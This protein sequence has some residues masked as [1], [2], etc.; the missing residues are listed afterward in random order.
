M[1][2]KINKSLILEGVASV[3]NDIIVN[4]TIMSA[5]RKDEKGQLIS[6]QVQGKDIFDEM[7]RRTGTNNKANLE[8]HQIALKQKRMNEQDVREAEKLK[9]ELSRKGI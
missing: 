5:P 1:I 6:G 8:A 9:A 3:A 7:N 2:Y 4:N